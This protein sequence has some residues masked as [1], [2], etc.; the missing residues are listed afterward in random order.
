MLFFVLFFA[1]GI[2][3]PLRP[4]LAHPFLRESDRSKSNTWRLS[5][6]VALSELG[7]LEYHV[8]VFAKPRRRNIRGLS[9]NHRLQARVKAV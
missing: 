1:R 3:H 8:P 6:N 7:P 9:P 4:R 5:R 2:V